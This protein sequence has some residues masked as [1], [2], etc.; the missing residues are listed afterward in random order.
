MAI[1]TI[2]IKSKYHLGE[3]GA[4][5][6][7]EVRTY[8]LTGNEPQD[9]R[10]RGS[11][12]SDSNKLNFGTVQVGNWTDAVVICLIP[13]ADS[14]TIIN[15]SFWLQSDGDLDDAKNNQFAVEQSTVWRKNRSG[16]DVWNNGQEC[17]KTEI[18][19]IE[20]EPFVIGEFNTTNE[21]TS[22]F[23]YLAI[24]PDANETGRM[25]S[26]INY[27]FSFEYIL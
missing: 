14:V 11:I 8:N 15:V 19:A 26:N 9:R 1:K 24:K 4:D 27:R 3:L 20:I 16:L 25:I 6:L 7:V 5:N 12:I 18:N 10:I 21:G 22:K 17:P 23:I 13:L 2:T